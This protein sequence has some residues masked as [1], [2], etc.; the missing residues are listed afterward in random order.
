VSAAATAAL[1]CSRRLCHCLLC[2][3]HRSRCL[4]CR[5]Y[6]CPHSGS[7]ASP[8]LNAN[9]LLAPPLPLTPPLPPRR[10]LCCCHRKTRLCP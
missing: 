6:I 8:R 7:A 9:P 2:R 10:H 3:R 1:L 5:L 4:C